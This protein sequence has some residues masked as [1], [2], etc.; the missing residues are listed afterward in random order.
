LTCRFRSPQGQCSYHTTISRRAACLTPAL[1]TAVPDGPVTL[2]IDSTGLK[3]HGAGEWHQHGVWAV[4][5]LHLAVD[6]A[7]NTIIAATLT[8]GSEMLVSTNYG[9]L[10]VLCGQTQVESPGF[11]RARLARRITI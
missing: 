8:T 5:Q 10:E 7:T 6:G 11:C 2:V 4:D 3:V 1:C 9:F